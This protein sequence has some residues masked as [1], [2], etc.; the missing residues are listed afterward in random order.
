M[1]Y[2]SP[3][4]PLVVNYGPNHTES[5][6]S[7]GS[8]LSQPRAVVVLAGFEYLPISVEI[9]QSAHGTLSTASVTLA[10]S[11][12]GDLSQILQSSQNDGAVVA[13]IYV[14]YP[15]N[16]SSDLK[17]FKQLQQRF[18]GIVDTLEPNFLTNTVTITMRSLGA[19]LE[20]AKHTNLS[21]NETTSAFVIAAAKSVGL[22]YNIV[23]KK[24][25]S[26]GTL[27]QVF[28]AD[29]AVGY[30]NQRVSQTLIDC[31]EYDDVDTWVENDV[32]N[33]CDPGSL[34]RKT[35]KLHW[36]QN[37][38][39]FT[40]KHSP[41]FNKNFKVEVRT[42]NPKIRFTH[43]T[44]YSVDADGNS[45]ASESTRETVSTTDFGTNTSTSTNTSTN[46]TTGTVS[47][48]TS[49]SSSDPNGGTFNTGTTN[50]PKD[51]S[52]E[53]YIIRRPNLT[54]ENANLLAV[55][56]AKQMS[57]NEFSADFSLSPTAREFNDITITSWFKVFNLPYARFNT[58]ANFPYFWP[59]R[60]TTRFEM[61]DGES[62][63]GLTVSI[64][65]VNHVLPQGNV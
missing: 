6:D 32:L 55:R 39:E 26:P 40:G 36:G 23:L 51:T 61:G 62:A 30:H 50:I 59:R 58:S 29:L 22:R 53:V 8:F 52:A 25:Q 16:P 31:A 43:T 63:A 46:L 48:S 18:W 12:S 14:G 33:Y 3:G 60:I 57:R 10:I 37:I 4:S 2:L 28:G 49:T 1:G 54:R 34:T 38:L 19:L 20:L 11:S 17:D 42:S 56:I 65:A 64:E 35:I 9:T 24:N 47:N 41:Q 44:R 45:V 15:A 27:G 21:L 13:R 7:S 5:Y